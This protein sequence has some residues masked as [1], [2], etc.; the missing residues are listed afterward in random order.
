MSD[1]EREAGRDEGME[2]GRKGEKKGGGRKG[3]TKGGEGEK[4]KV[5]TSC[6][7]QR[8]R[9]SL[10]K[11]RS[12]GQASGAQH[13]HTVVPRSSSEREERKLRWVKP[14]SRGLHYWRERGRKGAREGGEEGG[15]GG[16]REREEGREG[17]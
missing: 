8:G 9:W 13:A 5:D 6:T 10:T 2:E 11:L 7:L 3:G 15:K 16:R 12:G 17:E 1:G 14:L 4:E